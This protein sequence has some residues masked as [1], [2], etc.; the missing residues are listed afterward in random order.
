[1]GKLVSYA[2]TKNQSLQVFG[3]FKETW[4]ANARENAKLERRNAS[5]LRWSGV[6]KTLVLV[7][8]GAS[9]EENLGLLKEYRD[10]VDI[11]CCDKAFVP[12]MERGVRPDFVM[13]SDA[14]I[15]ARHYERRVFETKDIR[16]IATPYA[17]TLWTKPWLGPRYFYVNK[18]A[19]QTENIFL[20]IMGRETRIIA[21][22]SNVSNSML[23]FFM[24]RDDVHSDNWGGYERYLLVG[25]DYS[26]RPDGNYYAWDNPVPKR[27]YMNHLTMKDVGRSTVFTSQNLKF[28]ASW[29]T[30]YITLQNLPVVNCSGRG[31]LNVPFQSSLKSQLERAPAERRRTQIVQEHFKLLQSTKRAHDGAVSAFERAREDL[32]LSAT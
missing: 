16:L 9:L 13:I 20:P 17:N 26:W 30:D 7:A 14:N 1:M 6:G 25:Y 22:A 23:V 21:A 3:Q 10:R 27:H 5:E 28:S 2:D 29:L 15:P 8:M 11:V 32:W 24:G 18:D 12:L 19:I 31:I 4:L